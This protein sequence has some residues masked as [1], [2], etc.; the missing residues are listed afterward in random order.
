MRDQYGLF[1]GRIQPSQQIEG[2]GGLRPAGRGIAEEGIER[3]LIFDLTQ[4]EQ[5][6]GVA[7]AAPLD[8]G[9]SIS[10]PRLPSL[11]ST[12]KSTAKQRAISLNFA[13]S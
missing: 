1:A 7:A 9:F 10:P 3:G 2:A 4:P 13:L 11:W 12:V 5:D 6:G 8:Y